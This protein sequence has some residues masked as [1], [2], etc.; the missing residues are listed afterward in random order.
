MTTGG[1]GSPGTTA[2]SSQPTSP[3]GPS[4][5]RADRETRPARPVSRLWWVLPYCAGA[6]AVF[7][8]AGVI[9]GLRYN[10][11][12]AQSA[13]LPTA[14]PMPAEMFPDT[15]F[16]E[17]TADLQAGNETAF[18]HLAS[19]SAQPAI[20]TWWENLRAIGF[21]TGA[22]IPTASI[23]AVRIDSRGDGTTVVLAGA[24]SSLDPANRDDGKPY[25][26]MARYRV[27]LHFSGPGAIGQITS[28]QPLDDAP[29]DLGRP[30]YVRKAAGVVVAG[31]PGDSALVNQTLPV[32]EIAAAYDIGMMRH[33]SRVFLQQQGFVVFVS[34]SAPAAN[35]WLASVPQPQGWPP[36]FLGARAVELPGPGVTS[37]TAVSTGDSSLV[38][39][40]T[41]NDMGGVR[42]ILAPAEPATKGTLYA[43]TVTLVRVFM[44]DI[45]AT[46]YGQLVPGSQLQPVP[47][48]AEEGIAVAVQALFEAN[49][50]PAPRAYD[51]AT[52]AADL[53]ALPRS[54]RSGA[55]PSTSD[56][57]GPSVTAD[58]DWGDVAASAY[59]YIASRYN[60]KKMMVSAMVLWVNQPTPFG[61]VYK[62]GTNPNNLVFFGIHSIRLGW[63]PWLARF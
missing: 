41:D 54:Y 39:A 47:S 25:V 3:G 13:A 2:A 22:V 38:G 1:N 56:L 43:E 49:P 44:L 28:W 33:V 10:S 17:L 26:P 19:A 55:Y 31:P 45:L 46:Q 29:W 9:I 32:A 5:G 57:F 7:V 50:D 20:R 21:T 48:W 36:E 30:L 18:L 12:T 8:V 60:I 53:R 52:L 34:G 37:D 63:R 14:E 15:L 61:N 35:R 58:E 24:H 40:I 27:G 42:V 6:L 11:G 59:Y 4:P 51:W 16:G 62:S 23:D